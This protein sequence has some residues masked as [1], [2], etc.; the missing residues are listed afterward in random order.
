LIPILSATFQEFDRASTTVKACT[1]L[2]PVLEFLWAVLHKK[3]PSTILGLDN[4]QEARDWSAKL[5]TSCIALLALVPPP[6]IPP[7]PLGSNPPQDQSSLTSITGDLCLLRKATERQHLREITNEE[8]RKIV[9][10]AGKNFQRK[11]KQ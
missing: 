10:T 8:E 7:P 9:L 11:Y 4:S 2:R 6:F 3:I 5:H 1:V